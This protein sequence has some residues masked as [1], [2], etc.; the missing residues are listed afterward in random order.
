[1]YTSNCDVW[2]AGIVLM[3]MLTGVHPYDLNQGGGLDQIE[4]VITRIEDPDRVPAPPPPPPPE[5]H[6]V[7][8]AAADFAAQCLVWDRERRPTSA[9]LA[10][11]AWLAPWRAPDARAHLAQYLQHIITS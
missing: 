5:G 7:S 9:Q 2:S 11:H 6:G 8:E 4:A 3:E 10:E 1:M